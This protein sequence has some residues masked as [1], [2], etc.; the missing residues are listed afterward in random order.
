MAMICHALVCTVMRIFAERV[1]VMRSPQGELVFPVTEIIHFIIMST[2]VE[3][4]APVEIVLVDVIINTIESKSRLITLVNLSHTGK[5][6]AFPVVSYVFANQ[7]QVFLLLRFCGQLEIAWFTD[8]VRHFVWGN[9]LTWFVED[10]WR[11]F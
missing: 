7:V 3:G 11:I 10:E 5:D 6:F 4:A 9:L 8:F 1:V 2:K